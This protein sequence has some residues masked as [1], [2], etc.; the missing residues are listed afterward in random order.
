MK[1]ILVLM[2]TLMLMLG[3]SSACFAANSPI[4]DELITTVNIPSVDAII[5]SS[6]YNADKDRFSFCA[7]ADLS[8]YGYPNSTVEP[9]TF[10]VAR[11]NYIDMDSNVVYEAYYEGDEI[12]PGTVVK[13][14][15]GGEFMESY[16]MQLGTVNFVIDSGEI[17]SFA[18]GE[19]EEYYLMFYIE[20]PDD[21]VDTSASDGNNVQTDVE[22][23]VTEDENPKTGIYSMNSVLVCAAFLGIATIAIYALTALRG[24][25]R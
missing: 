14:F 4:A 1:K 3:L 9:F 7:V 15:W 24:E 8:A 25:S 11:E 21:L 6:S 5:I 22:D 20:L 12:E 13:I 18:E 19:F 16:P 10:G 2:F 23:D 17:Y